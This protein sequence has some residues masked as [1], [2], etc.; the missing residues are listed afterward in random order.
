MLYCQELAMTRVP[1]AQDVLILREEGDESTLALNVV[2]RE[3]L[4]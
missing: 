3:L 1:N 4:L 2:W